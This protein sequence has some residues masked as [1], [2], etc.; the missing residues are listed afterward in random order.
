MLVTTAM[1][2]DAVIVVVDPFFD[3][4]FADPG[5]RVLVTAVARVVRIVVVDMARHA[6]GVVVPIKAE[7]L[8]MVEGGR[9]P[10][11]LCMALAA[12]ALD[13]LM[14]GVARIAV[15]AVALF[16]QIGLHQFV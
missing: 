10:G 16:L 12:V 6:V 2:F 7:V 13:L 8:F 9:E 3:V 4:L 1:A 5:A 15:T 14:Q 11:L